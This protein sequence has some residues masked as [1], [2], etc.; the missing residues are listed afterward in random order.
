MHLFLKQIFSSRSPDHWSSAKEEA[1]SKCTGCSIVCQ[2]SEVENLL[3]IRVKR[4]L[5]EDVL[6]LQL[7]VEA[8]VSKYFLVM[9]SCF[10][11][12]S[13]WDAHRRFRGRIN[14]N[15]SVYLAGF[16]EIHTKYWEMTR[17]LK[18]GAIRMKGT[19]SRVNCDRTRWNDFRLKRRDLDWI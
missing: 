9:L 2:I 6:Q 8:D 5:P 10:L 19:D 4:S 18:E 16:F 14:W 3:L 17:Y 1:L 13:E 11:Y 12:Y 15:S 7:K